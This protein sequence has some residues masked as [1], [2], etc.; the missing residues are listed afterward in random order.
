MDW[1]DDWCTGGVTG[2]QPEKGMTGFDFDDSA[3]FERAILAEAV[4]ICVAVVLDR[5]IG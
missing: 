2:P 4:D 3:E 5:F 1:D